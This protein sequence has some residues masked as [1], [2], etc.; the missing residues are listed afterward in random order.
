MFSVNHAFTKYLSKK[1]LVFRN[2]GDRQTDG[3]TDGHTNTM[4]SRKC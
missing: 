1:M 3:R 4:I 2:N